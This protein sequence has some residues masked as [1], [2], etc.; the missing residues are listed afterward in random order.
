MHKLD[1]SINVI[2]E[3]T[4]RV[5]S[6]PVYLGDETEFPLPH[7]TGYKG[8][9]TEYPYMSVDTGA[10]A[11]KIGTRAA[12]GCYDSYGKDGRACEA[13]QKAI[14]EHKHGSVLEHINIGV[15]IEGVTR[16]LSLELNRHRHF[17]ISQ[18]STRYTDE[19]EAGIV[20]EPFYASVYERFG[21][22]LEQRKATSGADVVP[23]DIVQ[24][25]EAN[26]AY[27]ALTT[28]LL[29]AKEDVRRYASQVRQ[30]MD[31]N[32]HD[33]EGRDLRKWARGKARN[34]LP[35][36]LETCGTWTANV[37]AWRWVLEARTNRHAAD[38]IRRLVGEHI[39]P[40]LMDVAP[41]YFEDYEVEM[42]EGLPEL[43]T[44]Y[45]KV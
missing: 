28:H 2:T 30:L 25:D 42:V 10:H 7:V 43:Q 36:N 21:N 13:N 3:P 40:K 41:L 23:E 6:A 15:W 37:R 27:S 20:L 34:S 22:P 14:L 9:P 38:E 1:P 35:H 31:V 19:E 11:V 4:V 17:A 8:D 39:Y 16:A 33:L 44:E 45:N 18:R 12:K 5:V 29:G 26:A 24:D 32:P